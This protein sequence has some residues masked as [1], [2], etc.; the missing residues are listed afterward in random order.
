[1]STLGASFAIRFSSFVFCIPMVFPWLL[2]GWLA[3]LAKERLQATLVEAAQEQLRAQ[4]EAAQEHA[5]SFDVG[6]LFAL[7]AES[8]GL[9]D[10]LDRMVAVKGTP[11]AIRRGLLKGRN[12]V[13]FRSGAG[14]AAAAK[15]AETLLNA[16]LPTWIISA[17][18]CGGLDPRLKRQDILVADTIVDAEGNSISVALPDEVRALAGEQ[19]TH[20][21]KLLTADRI[22]CL[23]K[24]KRALGE[25]HAALGVDMESLAVAEVCRQHPT[26][27]LAVR[28]VSDAVGDELPRE[29]ERLLKQKSNASR[30]GAALG[31]MINRPG[32]VKDMYNLKENALLATDALGRFLARLIVRLIPAEAKKETTGK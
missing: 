23:P 8:G 1:M 14:R 12:V 26:R 10:M 11:F 7:G 24:D 21:G 16:H 18:F 20:V 25:K 6:L 13:L 9:E 31:A 2:R 4:A 32:S 5:G 27:F 29:V 22:I 3:N 15:A 28:V 17:G 19:K 30:W